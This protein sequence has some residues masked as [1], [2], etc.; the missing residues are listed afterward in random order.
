M[1]SSRI[2][3]YIDGGASLV[4]Y[5]NEGRIT[6][7]QIEIPVS[8]S[9]TETATTNIDSLKEAIAEHEKLTKTASSAG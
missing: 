8:P 5:V 2:E 9:C 6:L 1:A 4:S 3:T 7:T